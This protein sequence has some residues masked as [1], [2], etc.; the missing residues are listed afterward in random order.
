MA[1]GLTQAGKASM[2]MK[3]PLM[4]RSG[5]LRKFMRVI[6]SKTSLTITE[7]IRPRRENVPAPKNRPAPKTR[8]LTTVIPS[9][10]VS[11]AVITSEVA[12]P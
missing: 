3:T 12:M 10:R 9:R 4:N 8:G 11:P 2:D 1:T 6:A 5:N 7:A